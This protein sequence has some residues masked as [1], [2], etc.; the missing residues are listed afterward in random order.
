MWSDDGTITMLQGEKR[1][2]AVWLIYHKFLCAV[3]A[4]CANSVQAALIQ[5]IPKTLRQMIGNK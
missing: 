3:G 4:V 2:V 1:F 5:Q